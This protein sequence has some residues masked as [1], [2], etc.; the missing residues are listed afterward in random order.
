MF[1]DTNVK[2]HQK[3]VPIVKGCSSVKARITTD[4]SIK[5]RHTDIVVS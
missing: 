5:Y 3:L 4:S 1:L 2:L